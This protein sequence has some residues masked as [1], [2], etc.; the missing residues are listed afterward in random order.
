MLIIMSSW[1]AIVTCR[2]IAWPGAPSH[3]S[4]KVITTFTTKGVRSLCVSIFFFYNKIYIIPN[5][6]TRG[7]NFDKYV[8]YEYHKHVS[9]VCIGRKFK[10]RYYT[11]TYSRDKNLFIF[12][13]NARV[14]QQGWV[15]YG[16]FA[17]V[18]RRNFPR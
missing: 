5:C 3:R 18:S 11:A 16:V 10:T 6:T 14:Y 17:R 7:E 13:K 2:G 8:R 9:Y 12:S 1:V 15:L 4:E